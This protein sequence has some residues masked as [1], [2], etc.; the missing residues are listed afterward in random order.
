LP[1]AQNV[2][3]LRERLAR[4]G[5]WEAAYREGRSP[6]F[7]EVA[8]MA[9][10]PLEDVARALPHLDTAPGSAQTPERPS[11]PPARSPLT[12]RER[13]VLRLVA[14]QRGLF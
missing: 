11:Q 14:A 9:L 6:P 4:E 12:A 10:T 1:E 7:G 5:E 8:A 2:L 3:E 13:E